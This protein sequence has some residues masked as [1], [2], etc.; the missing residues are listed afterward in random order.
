MSAK[1]AFDAVSHHKEVKKTCMLARGPRNT[2]CTIDVDRWICT[3]SWNVLHDADVAQMQRVCCLTILLCACLVFRVPHQLEEV[4][5][6][7]FFRAENRLFRSIFV[8]IFLSAFVISLPHSAEPIHYCQNDKITKKLTHLKK[9]VMTVQEHTRLQ[10]ILG[11]HTPS[12]ANDSMSRSIRR[13]SPL[14]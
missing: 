9:R 2:S 7:L 13:S 4:M 11:L 8:A 3:T 12:L 14:R 5:D 10:I 6:K 1:L